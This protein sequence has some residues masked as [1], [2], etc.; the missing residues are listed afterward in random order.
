MKQTK[1]NMKK[2]ITL[3]EIILA[4]V[5]IAVIMGI[6]IPKLMSNSAKA[7]VK[8]VITSDVRSIVESA[9]MWKKASAKAKG[10]YKELSAGVLNSRLPSNMAVDSALGLIYSS[11]LKTGTVDANNVPQTGVKYTVLW[12]FDSTKTNT[13]HFSIGMD[14]TQGADSTVGLGWDPKLQQYAL[15]VFTDTIA[16]L[17]DGTMTPD[18]TQ[19]QTAS[20]ATITNG[21]AVLDRPFDC[22]NTNNVVCQGDLEIK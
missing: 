15:D 12:Q 9:N 22:T 21:V 8:Q 10:T 2:G 20:G 13:G 5:L 19:T 14:I 1:Q 11:G 6:T 3:I 4:I 16:E 17:T 7:E 18:S